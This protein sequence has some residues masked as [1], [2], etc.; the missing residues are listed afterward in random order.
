MRRIIIMTLTAL[1]MSLGAMAQTSM[2]DFLA[3]VERGNHD[4]AAARAATLAE[5]QAVRAANN[6]SD[7]EVGYEYEW[8]VPS[9]TGTEQGISI[10]QQFDFPTAY[11]NRR[12]MADNYTEAGEWSY[13]ALRADL[14]LE[15]QIAYMEYVT[16]MRTA[17]LKSERLTQ[18]SRAAEI[19]ERLAE[20]GEVSLPELNKARH[21]V[22]TTREEVV[23]VAVEQADLSAHLRALTGGEAVN[24]VGYETP[25]IEEFDTML[26]LYLDSDPT[27]LSARHRAAAADAALK[28]ERN[29][30]LPK[31]S[32]GFTA[33]KGGS[34]RVNA[35]SSGIT[36]PIFSSRA[37]VK[38][39][40]AEASAA[41]A[42]QRATEVECR[43]RLEAL[44]E[45]AQILQTSI[46]QLG[47]I[48]EDESY[49][50]MLVRL[51]ESGQIGAVDYF[52]EL[53]SY[54]DMRESALRLQLEFDKVAAAINMIYL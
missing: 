53:G 43:T 26:A 40:T 46:E 35:I 36:I 52:S 3:A 13:N 25:Y 20:Q 31:I 28:V 54:Y 45:Q 32:V 49:P 34:Q 41:A 15:A 7:P 44:Y 37:T 21:A 16:M 30:A 50:D 51:L 8:D 39:A 23:M 1:S 48:Y 11:I 12:R 5:S 47:D 24:P 10:S 6:L 42:E 14:L 18:T 19:Y 4:L 38:R 27:M 9:S 33:K 29:M 17:A 2:S 22:V